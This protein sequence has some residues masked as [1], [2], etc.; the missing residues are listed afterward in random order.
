MVSFEL[1]KGTEKD[2]LCLVMSIGQRKTSESP[3]ES[4]LRPSD[5][6]RTSAGENKKTDFGN[7]HDLVQNRK[8]H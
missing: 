5:S 3:E 6:A 8:L 7:K 4:N 1:G 2:L